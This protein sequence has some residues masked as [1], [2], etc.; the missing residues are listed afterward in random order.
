[1]KNPVPPTEAIAIHQLRLSDTSL[2]VTWMT[3]DWGKLKTS[4]RGVLSPKSPLA[5][6]VDLFHLV[7]I[8]IQ[9]SRRGDLHALKEVEIRRVFSAGSQSYAALLAAA[10]FARWIDRVTEPAEPVPEIYG[11]LDRGLDYLQSG[12]LTERGVF[13]FEGELA[14][15]LGIHHAESGRDPLRELIHYAGRPVAGREELLRAIGKPVAR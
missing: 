7:Q 12:K 8:T 3:R 4:A 6:R 9:A 10:Y 5:G 13:H 2:L 14:R 15:L 11:L 1:M